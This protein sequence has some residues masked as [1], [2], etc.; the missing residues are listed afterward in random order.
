[1]GKHPRSLSLSP[2][3][4]IPLRKYLDNVL[5]YES[6]LIQMEENGKGSNGYKLNRGVPPL[7]STY[8]A[9]ASKHAVALV[10]FAADAS[11][12]F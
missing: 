8:F 1:M 2:L 11:P 12:R 3:S 7:K 9:N 4:S 5:S 10:H 6:P